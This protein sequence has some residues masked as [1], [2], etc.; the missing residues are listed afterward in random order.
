MIQPSKSPGVLLEQMIDAFDEEKSPQFPITDT[1]PVLAEWLKQMEGNT[2]PDI[3]AIR[4]ELQQLAALFTG[5]NPTADPRP[6]LTSLSKKL[7]AL[8]ESMP[9]EDPE[10]PADDP[11]TPTL[12][13]PRKHRRRMSRW[14]RVLAIM[15]H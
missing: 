7:E 2:D 1:P 8:A 11:A 3:Q 13:R 9:D 4:S 5:G 14:A 15:G 6:L 10:G 12:G